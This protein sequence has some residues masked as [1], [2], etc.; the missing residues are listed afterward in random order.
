MF[1][2]WRMTEN[3]R[4]GREK[5]WNVRTAGQYAVAKEG[6][7]RSLTVEVSQCGIRGERAGN[8]QVFLST[9]P[10]SPTSIIPPMLCTNISFVY[11]RRHIL[12]GN[13]RRRRQIKTASASPP[14]PSHSWRLH[15]LY[16]RSV[17]GECKLFFPSPRC[18]HYLK[19]SI[20]N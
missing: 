5:T 13:R 18:T 7:C 10:L 2:K 16:F 9:L 4:Y 15:T 8:G 12:L 17:A 6:S 14:P 19:R 20:C 3:Y 1:V 11:H